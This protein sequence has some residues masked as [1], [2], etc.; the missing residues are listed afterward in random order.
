[1]YS[2]FVWNIL[3]R[4]HERAKG[5]ATYRYLREME[6]ADRASA[7]ELEEARRR[8]LRDL[9]EYSYVH[10]PYWRSLLDGRG[11][12]PSDIRDP[13]D[14]AALPLMRKADMRANREALRSTIAGKL[15]SFTTG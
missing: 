4:L 10:V 9:I 3:F 2:W 5:H 8:K 11:M 13:R 7:A 14:L 6:A 15:A 12:K 1:M